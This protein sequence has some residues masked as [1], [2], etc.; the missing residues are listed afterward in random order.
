[1]VIAM[2]GDGINDSPALRA[3]HVG[4]AMGMNGDAAAREV[5]DLFLH[6]EDLG[7]LAHAVE[8]GRTTHANIRKSLRFILS[9]NCS[10]VLLMF[11]VAAFGLGEG[12]IN[13]I[14]DVLPGIGLAVEET[15]PHALEKGPPSP[16]LPIIA[17]GEI[18]VLLSEGATLAAGAAYGAHRFGANSPICAA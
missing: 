6:T 5:A 18:G 13:V 8:Q 12:R 4:V 14:T 2:V 16:D 11:A 1:M 3:A 10:E 9:T 7:R 17:D 15:D